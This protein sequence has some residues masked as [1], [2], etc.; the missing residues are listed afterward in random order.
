MK[1]IDFPKYQLPAQV[2]FHSLNKQ[3]RFFASFFSMTLVGFY[4]LSIRLLSTPVSIIGT[5]ISSVFRNEVL[6]VLVNSN[7]FSKLFLKTLKQLIT[8]ALPI[9]IILYLFLPFFFDILLGKQWL[10]AADMGRILCFMLFVDFI[11]LP[12]TSSVFIL[13]EKQKIY[14]MLQFSA[15]LLNASAIL[16]GYVIFAIFIIVWDY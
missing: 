9:F 12:L 11:S 3:H 1:Y 4:S 6:K 7:D 8:I 16:I 2:L 13:K 15:V 10:K 14:L 5:S